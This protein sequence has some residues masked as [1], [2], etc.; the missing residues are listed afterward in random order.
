M[1]PVDNNGSVNGVPSFGGNY[2]SYPLVSTVTS[3]LQIEIRKK[4]IAMSRE[5]GDLTLFLTF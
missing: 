4:L 3:V 1:N 5:L 2:Y